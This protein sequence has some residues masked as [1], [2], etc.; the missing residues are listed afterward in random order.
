MQL[1]IGFSARVD[2]LCNIGTP[3]GYQPLERMVSRCDRLSDK[4]DSENMYG[5]DVPEN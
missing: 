1:E 2:M 3:Y 4:K 5:A